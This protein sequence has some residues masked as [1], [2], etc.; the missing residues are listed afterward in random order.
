VVVEQKI[1]KLREVFA[2][3]PELGKSRWKSWTV[4]Q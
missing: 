2:D 3:A 1:Q 4:V